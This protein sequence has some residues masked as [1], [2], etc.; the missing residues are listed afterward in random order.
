M[1]LGNYGKLVVA[2][3]EFEKGVA[4]I[5]A[6]YLLKRQALIEPQQ[7]VALHLFA[8]GIELLMK[9]GLFGKNFGIYRKKGKQIGHRLDEAYQ[10]C[11]KSFRL[12][13]L[14]NE[15]VQQL[16]ALSGLF[17]SHSL[18]YAGLQ[19]IFI[20][21]NSIDVSLIEAR[22]KCAM[23]LGRREFRKAFIAFDKAQT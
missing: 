19:D 6:T 8:Q 3:T 10:E 7:Y 5:A 9:G 12:N 21:P 14:C 2:N 16:K 13:P 18:R 23:R 17:S 1:G 15:S 20:A 22:V 4:F 11:T